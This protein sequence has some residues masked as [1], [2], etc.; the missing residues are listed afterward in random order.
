MNIDLLIKMTN[1]IGSF[2]AGAGDKS[3]APQA[4]AAHLKRYWEPRMRQQMLQYYRERAG[5]GLTELALAG[6]ALL[7]REDAGAAGGGAAGAGA[8]GAGAAGGGAAGGGASPR[9][10]DR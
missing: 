10:G 1:E 7:A 3:A 6:V 8:A 2:F 9:G 4:V 5:A